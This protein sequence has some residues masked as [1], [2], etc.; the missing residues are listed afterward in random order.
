MSKLRVNAFTVSADGFGAG[1]DQGREH[2]L[3]RGGEELH[4]WIIPTRTFQKIVRGE[5]RGNDGHRRRLRGTRIRG[6]RRVD[7]GPQHVRAGA[8]TVAG[9]RVEGLVGRQSAVPC[10]GLRADAPSAPAD[11]DGG[12]HGLPFRHRGDPR[13]ADQAREAAEGRTCGSA[14]ARRRSGSICGRG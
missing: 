9:R 8:R 6:C 10:A 11:R 14:A 4:G 7:H 3:G 13:G 5:G 2:P 12:R 1:P